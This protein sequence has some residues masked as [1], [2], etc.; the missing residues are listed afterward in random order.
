MKWKDSFL[1]GNDDIDEEH[2]R[3][4]FLI[5]CLENMNTLTDKM[6]METRLLDLETY[7]EQHFLNEERKMIHSKYPEFN[8]HQHDHERLLSVFQQ[9]KLDIE[10]GKKTIFELVDFLS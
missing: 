10:T 4:V 7:I 3:F 9:L 2:K 8:Q 1:V 5:D 6:E